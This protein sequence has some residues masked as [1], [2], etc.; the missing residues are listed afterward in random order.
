MSGDNDLPSLVGSSRA[1]YRALRRLSTRGVATWFAEMVKPNG[2]VTLIAVERFRRSSDISADQAEEFVRRVRSLQR[3]EHKNVVRPSDIVVGKDDL[4]LING[5]EEGEY[6]DTLAVAA[7]QSGT[8]FPLAAKLRILADILDGLQ[9]IHDLKDADGQPL[10]MIHGALNPSNVLVCVDGV[11]RLLHVCRLGEP[12]AGSSKAEYAA[13]EILSDDP[14]PDHRADIF[15]AGAILLESL[16]GWETLS[17]VSRI[18]R[19]EK[20]DAVAGKVK[21]ATRLVS[22]VGPLVSVAVR[23]MSPRPDHRFQ[24]VADMSREVRRMTELVPHE[25]VAALLADIAGARVEARRSWSHPSPEPEPSVAAPTTA[26]KPDAPKPAEI[27][28]PPKAE[29]ALIDKEQVA[30]ESESIA[31]PPQGP[32]AEPAPVAKAL[33]PI[34]EAPARI[35]APPKEARAEAAPIAQEPAPNVSPPPEREAEP[36]PRAN[37]RAAPIAMERA[38]PIAEERAALAPEHASLESGATSAS[39][40]PD[41]RQGFRA[42]KVVAAAV[43]ACLV[44]AGVAWLWPSKS[45]Q[46]SQPALAATDAAGAAPTATS[47]AP[48]STAASNSAESTAQPSVAQQAPSAAPSAPVADAAPKVPVVVPVRP[49]ATPP[50]N[51]PSRDSG[52]FLP[53]GI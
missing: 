52:A 35:A 32:A 9:A 37:E 27:A 3:L 16:A 13:A 40:P 34:A 11:S 19:E 26:V 22:W 48:L 42:W 5:F 1:E 51:P 44:V 49:S 31:S 10:G 47:T 53:E 18:L 21:E 46:P 20:P 41:F 2:Q 39:I 36:A 12:Q 50:R 6:L 45:D 7:E 29:P 30:R 38:A 17:K 24:S 25:E 15:S 33:A 4:L 8:L 28:Q 14:P 23:A 43:G